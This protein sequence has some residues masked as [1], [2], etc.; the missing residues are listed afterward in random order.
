MFGRHP[1]QGPKNRYALQVLLPVPGGRGP[2]SLAAVV[3][4]GTGPLSPGQ[5]LL[6]DLRR[7]GDAI[8]ALAADAERF[9]SAVGAF[10]AGDLR[11][12]RRILEARGQLGH[13]GAVLEWL[14]GIE[15]ARGC[16]ELCGAPPDE[17]PDLRDFADVTVRIAADPVLV[18]RLAAVP[19]TRDRERFGALMAELGVEPFCQLLSPWACGAGRRDPAGELAR[20]G[21]ALR[22][23]LA[24]EQLLGEVVSALRA[25]DG[26]GL[27]G[28]LAAAGLEDRRR[29]ICDWF[30]AWHCAWTSLQVCVTRP[31]AE[32]AGQ[33][34]ELARASGRLAAHP[35]DLGALVGATLAGD[36]VQFEAVLYR[37]RAGRFGMELAHWI[38]VAASARLATAS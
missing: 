1:G 16:R 3:G 7:G 27:R 17:L 9:G 11:S 31:A 24:D 21:Q 6:G 28:L 36:A 15:R 2:R 10:R 30:C 35:D 8:A 20:T 34:W 14:T 25:G 23:L 18:A 37:H 38:C 12:L 26:T 33:A 19:G 29:P 22:E 4:P 13:A 5:E 32:D